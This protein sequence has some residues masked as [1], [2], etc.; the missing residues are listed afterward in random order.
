[1]PLTCDTVVV[2]GI[3]ADDRNKPNNIGFPQLEL[4]L[5]R[6]VFGFPS[7]ASAEISE[8]Q[9]RFCGLT[10]RSTARS[11]GLLFAP[12]TVIVTDAT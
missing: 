2:L 3:T 1:M 5:T 9:D 10:V 4:G 12:E 6:F 7:P 11:M 8:H